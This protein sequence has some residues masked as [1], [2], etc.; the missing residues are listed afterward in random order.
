[1]SVKN[2]F[3]FSLP[4]VFL[5]SACMTYS[6]GWLTEPPITRTGAPQKRSITVSYRDVWLK[7]DPYP[8]IDQQIKT[9][10]KDGLLATNSFSEI[11]PV[12]PSED[13]SGLRIHVDVDEEGNYM[14]YSI[15]SSILTGL[16][17]GFWPTYGQVDYIYTITIYK[18]GSEIKKYIYRERGHVWMGIYFIG[19][20]VKGGKLTQDTIDNLMARLVSDMEK[21]SIL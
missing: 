14:W 21:D 1:M 2:K 9:A 16:S 15:P 19:G 10:L 13:Q 3:F 12:N 11:T 6:S 20:E 7:A 5:L 17:L 8:T 4:A 18:N